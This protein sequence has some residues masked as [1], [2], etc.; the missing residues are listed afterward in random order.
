[1]RFGMFVVMTFLCVMFI[2]FAVDA[3]RYFDAKHSRLLGWCATFSIITG[4]IA[5]VSL[6]MIIFS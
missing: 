2:R 5:F 3:D 4:I 1:M 6:I